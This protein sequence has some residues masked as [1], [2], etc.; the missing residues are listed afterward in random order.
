MI[1]GKL[2]YDLASSCT[3]AEALQFVYP[4]YSISSVALSLLTAVSETSAT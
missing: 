4:S 2:A 3:K 1:T